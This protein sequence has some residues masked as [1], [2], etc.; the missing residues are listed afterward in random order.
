MLK[1]YAMALGAYQTN[2][3]I[4]HE[5]TSKNCCVIDPGYDANAILDKLDALG[6]KLE[7]VLLGAMERY[8]D[9]TLK[10]RLN[11]YDRCDQILRDCL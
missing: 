11:V 1:V 4:I 7:A 9:K 10:K 5:E 3:Y 2:C 6:L 8:N